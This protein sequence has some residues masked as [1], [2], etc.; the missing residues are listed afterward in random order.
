MSNECSFEISGRERKALK[1]IML[2]VAHSEIYDV[3]YPIPLGSV[4]TWA[5]NK[6]G[7]HQL[8]RNITVC[9]S[10]CDGALVHV[11]F[12]YKTACIATRTVTGIAICNGC[13]RDYKLWLMEP[14]GV[15]GNCMSGWREIWISP[16]PESVDSSGEIIQYIPAEY[17]QISQNYREARALLE[18]SS[19]ASAALTRIA[20]EAVIAD[21]LNIREDNLF[22]DIKKIIEDGRIPGYVLDEDDLHAVR[23]VG[24]ISVHIFKNKKTRALIDVS[25]EDAELALNILE[26]LLDHCFVRPAIRQA[27]KAALKEKLKDGKS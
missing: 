1:W 2:G 24:N 17:P 23:E 11:T 12:E 16:K 13:G 4:K 6:S 19:R 3:L 14:S 7:V 26:D 9:C 18:I 5:P 22:A 10:G 15:N 20:L 25:Y 27:R 21:K 8:P